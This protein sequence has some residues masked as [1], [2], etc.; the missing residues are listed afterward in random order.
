MKKKEIE[1]RLNK[2]V[3]N[4]VPDVLD[5][6]LAQCEDREGVINMEE[7]KDKKVTEVSEKKTFK[8]KSFMPKLAGVMVAIIICLCGVIGYNQYQD[9]KMVDSI[10]DFDVNPGIEIKTNKNDKIIEVNAVND[11]GKKILEDMDLKNVDIDVAVNAIVGSMLKNGYLSDDQNSIL[12]SVKNPDESKAK[13]LEEEISKDINDLL[14]A[15]NIEASI[16]SQMYLDDDEITNL[17][18]QYGLSEGKANLI[19]RVLKSDLKNSKGKEYTFEELAKLTINDLNILLNSKNVKV[20]NVSSIG[21]ASEGA[22]IGKDKAKS[23]AFDKAGVKESNVREL[24]VEFDSDDGIFVYEVSFDYGKKEYEYDINA[25][26]GK[27]VESQ[28]ENNDDYYDDDNKKSN[29]S[30]SSNKTSSSSSSSTKTTGSKKYRDDDDDDRYDD[31]D[32]DDDDRDDR[33]DDDDD[34]DDDDRDDR[35]DDDDDDDDDRDD[36]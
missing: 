32:D 23:I 12:V 31:D 29:N 5:N 18:K 28:V 36:D 20:E 34:D 8:M 6:I 10:I 3:S 35:D 21:K 2:T 17:A 4:M 1:K 15:Q 7:N 26:T 19:S 24:E 22:Y 14:S 13:R 16:L 11:D 30:T 25:K 9:M 27:I 33:D